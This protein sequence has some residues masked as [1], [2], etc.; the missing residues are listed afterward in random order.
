MSTSTITATVQDPSG[1]VFANGTYQLIFKPNPAFPGP[2]TDG[3]TSFTRIFNG[4]LDG[5]G[6]FSQAGVARND[7]ILP[8]GSL[9]T[10][11]VIPNASNSGYQVDL[12]VN[13]ANFSA[14]SF[15]N[16]NISNISINAFP[17]AHAYKDAEIFGIPGSGS[18]YYDVTLKVVKVWDGALQAWQVFP[19]T[20]GN[21]NFASV[22]TGNLNGIR[23][24]DG[25]KFTTIQAAINDLPV[26]GGIVYIPAGTYTQNTPF[27]FPNSG[28][29]LIGEGQD[30]VTINTN[31]TT[32][33]L[34]P[35]NGKKHI[36]ISDMTINN[37]GTGGGNAIRFFWGQYCV[38]ERLQ[39]TGVFTNGVVFNSING[40]GSTI[41]NRLSDSLV[42]GPQV[43]VLFDSQTNTTQTVNANRLENSTIQGTI[44]GCR[45]SGGQGGQPFCNENIAINCQFTG[46]QAAGN[47][48]VLIDNNAARDFL[49]QACTLEGSTIG[50]QIGSGCAGI[51]ALACEISV[52]TTQ[53]IDNSGVSGRTY[54]SGNIGG[55]AQIYGVSAAGAIRAVSLAFGAAADN[56]PNTWS[57]ATGAQLIASG[58]TVATLNNTSLEVNQ[59]IQADSSIRL[60]EIAAPG[61]VAGQEVLYAD[62]TTHRLT[63]KDNNGSAKQLV[64]SGVDINTSDQVTATH[65]SSALPVN[66]GGTGTTSTLSGVL[67]GGN[68]ITASAVSLTADVSG[69]LPNANGGI[70]KVTLTQPATGS[71]LTILDGKTLTANNSLTLAGT[72]GTILTHQGTG[73]V[74][75]RDSTD[76]L[77]NKTLNAANN[78]N[79]VTLLNVQNNLADVTGTGADATVFSY[80]IP[81]NIIPTGKAIRVRFWVGHNTGAAGVN[82]KF[83]FGSTTITNYGSP[84]AA[85][86]Q[87]GGIIIYNQGSGLATKVDEPFITGTP[88]LQSPPGYGAGN[89]GDFSAGFTI[90][91]T[92]N[93]ANTDKVTPQFWI[94][95]SIL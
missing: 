19:L 30:A 56:G 85:G 2:Y 92:M 36:V 46:G 17:L 61:G 81:A 22:T 34:F 70:G 73:T 76:T 18:F 40:S 74:V 11:I 33:D 4:N 49:M 87:Q 50:L 84:S 29:A 78:A 13:S 57:F 43:G 63:S 75:N 77:S 72:D 64:E 39:I 51:T 95:E 1:Q 55:T 15:I 88:T 3:G 44:H 10:L 35:I 7:T 37:N 23:F 82:Y 12:N 54:I 8:S 83:K 48:G 62:S 38:L 86:T 94:V 9:W 27:S 28:I 32:G 45:I 71:T 89:T 16:A 31:I 91:L 41:F 26:G 66:Q 79:S 21:P 65:L 14:T 90:S 80:A 47:C 42:S 24:V 20:G 53:V 5:T 6:S 93:V 60:V 69:V 25:I 68:P 58:T 59:P 67:H 52:N